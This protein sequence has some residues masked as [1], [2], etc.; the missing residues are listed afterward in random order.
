MCIRDRCNHTP[1]RTAI[2]WKARDDSRRKPW[3]ND[4]QQHLHRTV[5]FSGLHS[6]THYVYANTYL[7]KDIKFCVSLVSFILCNPYKPASRPIPYYQRPSAFLV[8]LLLPW[9]PSDDSIT[10]SS[11]LASGN[12]TS[13]VAFVLKGL[14]LFKTLLT[15]DRCRI[16]SFRFLSLKLSL[17]HI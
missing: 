1:Q 11:I 2:V 16:H 14:L 8:P 6:I 17:I 7:C 4:K 13:I 5:Y 9:S 3:G 15:F 12:V 10:S